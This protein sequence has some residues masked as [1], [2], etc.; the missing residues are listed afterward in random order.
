M[1]ALISPHE[2]LAS[3]KAAARPQKQRNLDAVHAVCEALHKA[4]GSDF[5][6][7]TVGRMAHER[8][9]PTPR[10]MYTA[11]SEDFRTLVKAWKDFSAAAAGKPAL[12]VK[13][14]AEADWV[15]R[16]DDPAVRALVAAIVAER[17]SLRAQINV[18]R[19]N[20][21]IVID[22]R[23]PQGSV[24]ATPD[25]QVLQVVS[26]KQML[27][28]SEREALERAVSKS[29]LDH[30]GWHEGPRGEIVNDKGRR[31]FEHGFT[32]AIRKL[33]T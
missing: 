12:K 6:L 18:L 22:R 26:P 27:S 21:N 28:D 16:I 13:P 17:N 20:A 1:S 8:G 9:G 30:E 32:A 24:S 2:V 7:A 10:T 31:L 33:L 25:G 29:F 11:Q 3:L 23:P 15:R 4:G 14:L 19:A 5:A